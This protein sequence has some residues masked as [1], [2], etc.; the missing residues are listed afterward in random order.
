MTTGID[1]LSSTLDT[2]S[3]INA[4]IAVDQQPQA[5][6]Q[7]QVSTASKLVSALQGLNSQISSLAALATTAAAPNAFNVFTATS[8]SSALTA[9]AAPGA[10]VG[11]INLVVNQLAQ[12][13]T[14]VTASMAGWAANPAALTIVSSNG[15]ATDI[16][17]ASNSLDDIVSAVNNS[18]TGVTAMKV[19]SGTVA[20]VQQYRL[21][22]TST[23]TGAASAFTV[24][25]GTSADVTGGTATNLL[26]QP[27][28]AVIQTAQDAQV[29]LWSG[30][31]AE[32]TITSS[33]NSFADLLPGV[34]V[35]VSA[36]SA[37][38]VT[39]TIAQDTAS[40]ASTAS[41]FVS[42]LT[43]IF[44]SISTQSAVVQSTDSTGAPV[45]SASVFTGDGTIRNVNQTLLDAA[46]LP[47]NG[48]SPSEIGVSITKDGTLTFD[49]AKFTAALAADPANVQSMMQTIASRVASAATAASDPISGAITTKITGQNSSIKTMTDEISNWDIRLAARRASL[50]TTYAAMEV[51][52]GNLKS[53]SSYLTSQLAGLPT[54]Q[55]TK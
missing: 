50:E 38:P 48:H 34:A 11:S 23:A 4:L 9:T 12:G 43:G 29:S 6:L 40:I 22:F 37:T 3:L 27:G 10:S 16:T 33:T 18:T 19:A 54:M 39:L 17:P 45:T 21:Q 20:G 31:A 28:A 8:S 52:L 53:Q 51:T 15:T 44:A 42:S 41:N 30:T 26:T 55:Y 13:Q 49:Q 2:T 25:Q 5:Q 32:Q 1:G 14:G 24:Y 36:A 35:T 47:V 7:A 46:S